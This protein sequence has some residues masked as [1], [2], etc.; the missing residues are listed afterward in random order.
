MSSRWVQY[1]TVASNT[2]FFMQAKKNNVYNHVLAIQSMFQNKL[3][4]WKTTVDVKKT[5]TVPVVT[6]DIP[7]PTGQGTF[8]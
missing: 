5:V 8:V 6:K 4:F 3:V 2:K 7:T 1:S